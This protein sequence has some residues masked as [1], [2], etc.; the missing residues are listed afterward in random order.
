[1]CIIRRRYIFFIESDTINGLY[2][3]GNQAVTAYY[4][5]FLS[6][7]FTL[8]KNKTLHAIFHRK[9]KSLP[10]HSK[11]LILDDVIIKKVENANY[12]GDLF[13]QHLSCDEQ[14]SNVAM[15]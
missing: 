14:I 6:N 9:Q 2:T 1:M 7:S 5:W 11:T 8:N 12:F 10:P 4:D 13:D 15:T 3:L